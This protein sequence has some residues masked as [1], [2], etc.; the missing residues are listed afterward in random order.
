MTPKFELGQEVW[1][2]YDGQIVSGFVDTIHLQKSQIMYSTNQHLILKEHEL[3]GHNPEPKTKRKIKL[4]KAIY[5]DK[6]RYMTAA[7]YLT[8]KMDFVNPELIVGF[9]EMEAEI[10][11]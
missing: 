10:E 7:H 6:N 9:H 1:F 8:N 3:T 11:E 5:K 2:E 4:Y